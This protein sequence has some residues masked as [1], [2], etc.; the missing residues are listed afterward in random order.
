MPQN[1]I[2][3]LR[4][5]RMTPF[6]GSPSLFQGGFLLFMISA[7]FLLLSSLSRKFILICKSEV[8]HFIKFIIGIWQRGSWWKLAAGLRSR[9]LAL[10]FSPS[11]PNWSFRF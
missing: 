8:L 1:T 7:L 5:S 2:C 9:N 10:I 6:F 3:N 11:V 4:N